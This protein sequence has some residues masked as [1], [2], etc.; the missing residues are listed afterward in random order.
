MTSEHAEIF[1]RVDYPV[2]GPDT[3]NEMVRTACTVAVD[4]GLGSVTVNGSKVKF[5][6]ILTADTPVRV[7]AVVGGFPVGQVHT[8]VKPFEAAL[9][10][11][12]GAAEIDLMMNVGF[13][14]E[15]SPDY[16]LREVREVVAAAQGRPVNVVLETGYL[17]DSQKVKAAGIA[18]DSGAHGVV[19]CSGFGPGG[20]SVEDVVLLR[21]SLPESVA[22][23]A[24]GGVDSTEAAVALVA[25]GAARVRV[26]DIAA[27]RQ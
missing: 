11:Q 18:A 22:V 12:Q 1:G 27:V 19:T 9:A 23:I 4:V 24:A 6:S 7:I 8:A 3:T 15:C 10:V 25:A 17:S 2:L 26:A 14:T 5:A 21:E 16:L 13:F 20:A